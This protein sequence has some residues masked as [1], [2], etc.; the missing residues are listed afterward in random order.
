MRFEDKDVSGHNYEYQWRRSRCSGPPPGTGLQDLRVYN[1]CTNHG[2]GSTVYCT[3]RRTKKGAG[4]PTWMSLLEVGPHDPGPMGGA[5][6][7]CL[8]PI[9]LSETLTGLI[10]LGDTTLRRT[11]PTGWAYSIAFPRAILNEILRSRY[12][13]CRL[14]SLPWS[15]FFSQMPFYF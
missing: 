6:A 10:A 11:M 2:H 8:S 9:T 3:H 13:H 12:V 4:A 1:C 14:S 5:V 15:I 7:L